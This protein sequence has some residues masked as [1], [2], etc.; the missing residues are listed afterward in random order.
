MPRDCL[1]VPIVNFQAGPRAYVRV[2]IRIRGY[3]IDCRIERVT[4]ANCLGIPVK[5][6]AAL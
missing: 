2:Y 1:L 6:I 5:F 3:R 4:F